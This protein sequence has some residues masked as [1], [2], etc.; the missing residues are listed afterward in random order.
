MAADSIVKKLCKFA[1][2]RVILPFSYF[3]H[4][5][6]KVDEKKVVFLEMR[7]DTL[8]D[9]FALIDESLRKEGDWN[10]SLQ[11]IGQ[12]RTGFLKFLK[13]CIRMTK[14]IGNARCVFVNEGSSAY[15]C[16]KIRPETITIQTWHA[17]GAFKKF[18]ISLADKNVGGSEE[19][20]VKYPVYG[21]N[22][23]VTVSSPEVVWAYE[24][25]MNIKEGDSRR[26]V[27]V[28]TSRTDVYYDKE[29]LSESRQI[30]EKTIP[31]IVGKKIILYAPTFR[32][33]PTGGHTPLELDI[34]KFR[35]SIPSEYVLLI[36]HH[37]LGKEKQ[38]IPE[39]CADF[40]FD[41]T[42]TFP[43]DT[44]LMAADICITDYSSLIFEYS[45]LE[46]PLIFFA[47]DI[48]DYIDERGFYYPFEQF[49]PGPIVRTTEELADA[50]CNAEN[51]DMEKIRDFKNRFMA[52][53]DGHATERIIEIIKN[54][55]RNI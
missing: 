19:E 5:R 41:I 2:M 44:A 31:Q 43:I 50:V 48:D 4:S 49:C 9:N 8:S 55:K 16:L 30:L 51:A 53:C 6:G 7:F 35:S 1:A 46:R 37:P 54:G 3:L 33:E 20:Y 14:D 40:A 10:I 34:D 21:N 32:G 36:K 22:D 11:C 29:K 27:P 17:C 24:E 26:V 23:F 45:L 52:S 39:S 13:N 12:G 18:G 42:S 28:G 38:S 15:G 47:Y 25:A